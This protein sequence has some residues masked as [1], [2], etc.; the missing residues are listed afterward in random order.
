M[1]HCAGSVGSGKGSPLRPSPVNCVWRLP[2]S[3]VRGSWRHVSST[4]GVY[5]VKVAD[6]VTFFCPHK[7]G[8]VES[9]WKGIV[10]CIVILFSCF[11]SGFQ[12]SGFGA[13][14]LTGVHLKSCRS[15][16]QTLSRAR[17]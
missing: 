2:R 3:L 16:V 8:L 5:F 11:A 17:S 14:I 12:L 15:V 9:C 4:P 6:R 7:S 1:P 13:W 10:R